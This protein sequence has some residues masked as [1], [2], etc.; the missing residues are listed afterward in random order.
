MIREKATPHEYETVGPFERRNPFNN[1]ELAKVGE[2]HP[3]A[4]PLP[5]SANMGFA[6]GVVA[7][8][9]GAILLIVSQPSVTIW[10]ARKLGFYN[11]LSSL[12][13]SSSEVQTKISSAMDRVAQSQN[14]GVLFGSNN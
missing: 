11:T 1:Y 2:L 12:I 10:L 13:L 6:L 9:A 8:A 7:G 4:D 3:A 14:R 5:M